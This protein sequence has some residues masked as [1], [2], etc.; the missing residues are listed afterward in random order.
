MNDA[1]VSWLML[2]ETRD[3][4]DEFERLLQRPTWFA[5]A[6]C[7]GLDPGSFVLERGQ[8]ATY[9]RCVCATCLVRR[10]CLDTALADSTLKGLWG[11]TTDDERKAIRRAMRAG[12]SDGVKRVRGGEVRVS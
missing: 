12:R 7:R 6:A 8:V 1:L 4:T 3:A 10:E 5:R 11:A 9:G 2:P